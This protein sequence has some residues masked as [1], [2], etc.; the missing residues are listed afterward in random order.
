MFGPHI[1]TLSSSVRFRAGLQLTAVLGLLMLLALR[2]PNRAGSYPICPVRLVTGGLLCPGCGSMRMLHASL[3][4]NFL[5]AARLNPLGFAFLPM[6]GWL[7]VDL[8]AALL[9]G[10][11]LP[12][13]RLHPRM[14][15][16][17]LVVILAYAISRNVFP[18]M[19][20]A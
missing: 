4:G 16:L 13:S 15:W 10:Q 8:F 3:Q 6:I 11:H 17:L 7:V 2:D 18:W 1:P 12:R 19:T 20:T 14:I 9:A 5:V